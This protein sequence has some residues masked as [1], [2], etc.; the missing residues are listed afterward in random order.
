MDGKGLQEGYNELEDSSLEG[1]HTH[2]TY[3]LGLLDSNDTHTQ[4]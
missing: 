1:V 2:N 3:Y 4:R